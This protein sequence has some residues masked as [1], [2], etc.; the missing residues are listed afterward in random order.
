MKLALLLRTLATHFGIFIQG[1][2]SSVLCVKKPNLEFIIKICWKIYCILNRL[3][4]KTNGTNKFGFTMS[5]IYFFLV[6]VFGVTGA[7]PV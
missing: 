7:C 2:Y 5:K 3:I 1:L 4:Q 6:G